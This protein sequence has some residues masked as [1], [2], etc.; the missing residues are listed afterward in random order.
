MRG[1]VPSIIADASGLH[2]KTKQKQKPFPP[3]HEGNLSYFFFSFVKTE[4][5][6]LFSNGSAFPVKVLCGSLGIVLLEPSN[7]LH[8]PIQ[9]L[10]REE[11]EK[12]GFLLRDSLK[13]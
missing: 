13:K 2:L 11:R 7:F 8:L 12:S 5:K 1:R 4:A 3:R 10:G 9:I 6:F